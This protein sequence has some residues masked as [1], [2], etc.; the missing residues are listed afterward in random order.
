VG[1]L[2]KCEEEMP[3]WE[4]L[5]LIAELRRD[6]EQDIKKVEKE[7]EEFEEEERKRR[8][9]YDAPKKFTWIKDDELPHFGIEELGMRSILTFRCKNCG[10]RWGFFLQGVPDDYWKCPNGCNC[11]EGKDV[12]IELDDLSN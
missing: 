10:R 6:I 4:A 9:H 2:I 8:S 11:E 5:K 7:R 1:E 12:K 3:L